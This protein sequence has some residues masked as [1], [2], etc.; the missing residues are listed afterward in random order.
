LQESDLGFENQHLRAVPAQSHQVCTK[1]NKIRQETPQVPVISL[2]VQWMLEMLTSRR[3]QQAPHAM[4]QVKRSGC[5]NEPVRN[6]IHR[7]ATVEP[8]EW[9]VWSQHEM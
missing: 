9:L 8:N 1:Q 3:S 4:E 2:T 7:K 6:H 5:G